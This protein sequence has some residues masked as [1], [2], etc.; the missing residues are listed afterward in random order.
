MLVLVCVM[1]GRCG[2]PTGPAHE[3]ARD[4]HSTVLWCQRHFGSRRSY[5]DCCILGFLAVLTAPPSHCHIHH[6]LAALRSD[7]SIKCMSSSTIEM[8][9]STGGY[10]CTTIITRSVQWHSSEDLVW[11]WNLHILTGMCSS[12]TYLVWEHEQEWSPTWTRGEG[13]LGGRWQGS[14]EEWLSNDLLSREQRHGGLPAVPSRGP[15]GFALPQKWDRGSSGPSTTA[16]GGDGMW[17][18]WGC[19]LVRPHL[20]GTLVPGLDKK[21]RDLNLNRTL[22]VWINRSILV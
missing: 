5:F 2:P 19:V 8:E 10:T 14:E 7:F 9:T 11:S 22:K 18:A 21:K 4:L 6:C 20:G 16:A 15:R 13:S 3:D 12:T 17:S 1:S